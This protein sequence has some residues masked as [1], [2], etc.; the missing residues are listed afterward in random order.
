MLSG[1][2]NRKILNRQAILIVV[3][4]VCAYKYNDAEWI[5]YYF[6]NSVCNN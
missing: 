5:K 2:F 1:H 6:T 4:C 3:Q